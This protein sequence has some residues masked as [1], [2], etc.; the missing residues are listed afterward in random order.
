MSGGSGTAV[1]DPA[2][3]AAGVRVPRTLTDELVHAARA[4]AP[5]EICGLLVGS[6]D[7]VSAHYPLPNASASE[8]HYSIAPEDQLS[9]YLRAREEDLEVLGVYHS[10]PASPARP[11]ATDIAQ[12]YDPEALHVIV[13]LLGDAEMRAYRIREGT[14]EEVR[15]IIEEG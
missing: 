10:H 1:H 2:D 7:T 9:A 8:V 11:S 3:G 12:A 14:A 15:L 4:G 6:G 13:S 5:L